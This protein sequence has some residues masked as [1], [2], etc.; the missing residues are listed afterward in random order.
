LILSAAAYWLSSLGFC[1]FYK[2][3]PLIRTLDY[4]VLILLGCGVA[5]ELMH[6]VMH[7]DLYQ[8]HMAYQLSRKINTPMHIR[9]LKP[10]GAVLLVCCLVMLKVLTR[11][12]LWKNAALSRDIVP[13]AGIALGLMFFAVLGFEMNYNIYSVSLGP[14]IV[15]CLYYSQKIRS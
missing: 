11:Y 12:D 10:Q 2:E 1:L 15:F 9:F 4:W 8:Q 7:F 3:K 13:V 6:I 5:L 14:A